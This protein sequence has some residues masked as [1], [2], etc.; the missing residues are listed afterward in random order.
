[1]DGNSPTSFCFSFYTTQCT[2]D[3]VSIRESKQQ[4]NKK[5]IIIIIIIL[6]IIITISVWATVFIVNNRVSF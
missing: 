1:M 2:D 6:I 5:I 3:T 4:I